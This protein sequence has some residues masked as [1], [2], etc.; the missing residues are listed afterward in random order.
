MGTGQAGPFHTCPWEPVPDPTALGE[1]IIRAGPASGPAHRCSVGAERRAWQQAWRDRGVLTAAGQ[2]G[3]LSGFSSAH[4]RSPE[5][6][7]RTE[8][9]HLHLR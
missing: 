1:G 9:G 6:S 5:M 8:Q 3:M 7:T 4:P 2:T